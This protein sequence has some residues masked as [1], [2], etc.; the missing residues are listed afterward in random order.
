MPLGPHRK[1][2]LDAMRDE[3]RE[4]TEGGLSAP[5]AFVRLAAGW[6]GFDL[7]GDQFVDSKG[8]RGIDFW[9]ASENG[10]NVFQVKSHEL[11]QSGQ[12]QT[13]VFGIEGINDVRRAVELLS[14]EEAEP[15][16]NERLRQLL[17]KWDSTLRRRR[18]ENKR[19]PLHV[20]V[21]LVVF[22]DGLTPQ[23][24]DELDALRRANSAPR[25]VRETPVEFNVRLYTL[26]D[27]VD[28]RWRQENREWTD[29]VGH[30]RD[31]IEL[32]PESG[33][34]ET[35]WISGGK[36]ATF[37]CRAVDLVHAF[38][39]FGYQVF[40]PNVRAH[41]P[42]SKVNDAIRESLRHKRSR[43]E[44]RF[45]NNGVTITCQRFE[46]PKPPNRLSFRVTHPGVVNGLQTVMALY[47]TYSE[48]G[49]EDQKHF[50]NKCYLLV[51]ILWEDAVHDIKSVV[52]AT[53]TQNP[54]Q[55]RN[56]RSNTVEQILYEQQFARLG[57]FYERKQGAWEAFSA[58]PKRWR[59][60]T[61][62]PKGKFQYSGGAGRKRI[63]KLDNEE[64]AQTWLSLIG[65][66]D[67]AVHNKRDLFDPDKKWY[68]LTFLKRSQHHAAHYNF[69]DAR[70]R[71]DCAE[72]APNPRL[73]LVS[74]LAREF[75]KSAALSAK[76]NREAALERL[77]RGSG[78][79]AADDQDVEIKLARDQEYLLELAIAGM[80]FVFVDFLGFLLFEA[81]GERVHEAGDKLLSSGCLKR[82]AQSNDFTWV[83]S[84]VRECQFEPTD[85]LCLGWHAF[86]STLEQLLGTPWKELYQSARNRSRFNHSAENRRQ[87]LDRFKQINQFM[88]RT[89]LME[90]W[91]TGIPLK[92]GLVRHLA[93][94]LE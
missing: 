66:S 57:W 16:G 49:V 87:I 2:L 77:K 65:F 59:T 6:L 47:D 32:N 17:D 26:E 5:D 28:A 30:K 73:L 72:D 37:F 43:E 63:R 55:P 89:T 48:L 70:A 36:H 24:K 93:T 21:G 11:S 78:P 15:A 29:R 52:L 58:D 35:R 88:E 27:I 92:T 4:M 25:Q 68:D 7:E 19:D 81:V 80:T 38:E 94:V 64:L 40:E 84:Y 12:L 51:R 82:L 34:Q 53:N 71:A 85:V 74:F 75:A 9:Y 39:D 46:K 54:M 13:E 42:K 44:F 10:W 8:E 86:R 91:A 67:D 50:E 83:P 76:Q 14:S 3:I 56:L 33:D 41:I 69:D 1:N 18:H 60:L 79:V 23:A 90:T 61:N 62:T 22:G 20:E 31:W 45:L